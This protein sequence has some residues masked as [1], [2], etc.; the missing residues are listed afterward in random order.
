MSVQQAWPW[1]LYRI[2]KPFSIGFKVPKKVIASF[3]TQYFKVRV[4]NIEIA[5][6][7]PWRHLA[8]SEGY[9]PKRLINPEDIHH[10]FSIL[11]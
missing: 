9:E 7:P 3:I 5:A 8:L 4:K 10:G 11:E 2:N 6:H 1:G